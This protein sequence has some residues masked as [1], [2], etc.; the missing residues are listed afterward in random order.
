MA[1]MHTV[2]AGEGAFV[3]DSEDAIVARLCIPLSVMW[4]N[5]VG[6]GCVTLF[7]GFLEGS[8]SH[9]CAVMVCA[10]QKPSGPSFRGLYPKPASLVVVAKDTRIH[11]P[12]V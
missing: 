4:V 9:L 8:C 10:Q 2:H 11:Q 1:K 7:W 12:L 3:L 6:W 5:P